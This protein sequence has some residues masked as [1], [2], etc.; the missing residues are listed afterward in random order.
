MFSK[1]LI[2][3]RGE[4]AIRVIRACKE[5]GIATVAVYSQADKDALHVS[6]A[7]ES[8]CIGK[9][10]PRDSYLNMNNIIMAAKNFQAE[11]IHPGYGFLS[12]NPDFS[13]LCAEN[14]I[15]FIGP[16]GS[17]IA[18]MGDKDMARKTMQAAGVPIIPG[19]ELVDN[20]DH[21]KEE[22]SKIGFP[23]LIKARAGGGGRGI[24]LVTTADELESQYQMAAKEAAA[25]FNDGSVYMEKYLTNVK[26]IETQILADNFGNVVCLGERDCSMQRRNQKLVE[27]SPSPAVNDALRKRLIE[28]SVKAA[29]AVDYRGAGTIECLYDQKSDQFYFMEM[30]TRLQVEHPVTEFVTDIDLVKWQIRVAANIPLNFTQEDIKLNGYALECRI[31]AEDENFKPSCG[32]ITMLHVPGGPLVRFDSAIYNGY[33]IPPFYDSMIGKLVV[34]SRSS[35]N[36]AIRKMKAAL[37]ELVIEGVESNADLQMDIMNFSDFTEGGYTT[38]SLVKMLEEGMQERKGD[39]AS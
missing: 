35:R 20:P 17:V 19:C 37:A 23:L 8:C 9:A 30:N 6:L 34:A 24:R 38:A 32:K 3:N 25:A 29:K 15:V 27:E 12:E 39:G 13:N 7:E 26:H 16:K 22:G 18:Q 33:S 21:A 36:E 11:A 4:I 31:N 10:A 5:M 1:I 14:D 28:T 2:A